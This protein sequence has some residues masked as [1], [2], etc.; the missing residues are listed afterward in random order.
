[1]NTKSRLSLLHQLMRT[2]YQQ[3][4]WCGETHVQ[5]AA[6]F[7]QHLSGQKIFPFVLYK[8][9]PFSFELRNDL[10]MMRTYGL[11]SRQLSAQGYGPRL[12][13]SDNEDLIRETAELAKD[14]QLSIDSVVQNLGC[15]DVAELERLATALYFT[16]DE[17]V[18]DQS[19]RVARIRSIKP[20]IT[21]IDAFAAVR[22]VEEMLAQAPAAA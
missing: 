18:S 8:F 5:K 7:L 9:R 12:I 17:P 13:A 15:A 14:F 1:M 3:G 2:L 19:A 4:S 20:H 16:K 21:E 22:R 10:E 11:L 6:F